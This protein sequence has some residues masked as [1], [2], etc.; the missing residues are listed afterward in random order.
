[1]PP[2]S[3]LDDNKLRYLFS[4]YE[5]DL[6]DTGWRNKESIWGKITYELG[7]G[8]TSTNRK[9]CYNIFS[10]LKQEH[11]NTEPPDSKDFHETEEIYD[12]EL[13]A[14][15]NLLGDPPL[16]SPE[17]EVSEEKFDKETNST[18][19]PLEDESV[20]QSKNN[21]NVIDY[22][23]RE[24]DSSPDLTFSKPSSQFG[25][26]MS[27]NETA[28]LFSSIPEDCQENSC[29]G[30][31]VFESNS[32]LGG[33][34]VI[35]TSETREY[36]NDK[37]LET[38]DEADDDYNSSIKVSPI[39]SVTIDENTSTLADIELKHK[40]YSDEEEEKKE[41]SMSVSFSENDKESIENYNE[42]NNGSSENDRES[43]ETDYL[44][45]EASD[46]LDKSKKAVSISEAKVDNG[47]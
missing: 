40:I 45:S 18:S 13:K 19:I 1:M 25:E 9:M 34:N 7:I 31:G 33:D 26:L 36:G 10:R 22:E 43:D 16:N 37:Y 29:L 2:K 44:D 32:D 46:K 14:T 11:K 23:E 21:K 8:N 35:T 28:T 30:S 15:S 47:K 38:L 42:E 27:I 4:K 20:D 39:M 5:T 24:W 3:K 12:Q 6:E 17:S 41:N